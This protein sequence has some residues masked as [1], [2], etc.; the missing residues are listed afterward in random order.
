VGYRFTVLQVRQLLPSTHCS[1][2]VKY[3]YRPL[4]TRLLP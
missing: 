1:R 4:C 3:A 2:S